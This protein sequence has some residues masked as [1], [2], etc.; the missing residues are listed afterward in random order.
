[1]VKDVNEKQSVDGL[2]QNAVQ[3]DASEILQLYRSMRNGPA[4]W[5]DSYPSM[6]TI[7]FDLSRD[8]LFAMKNDDGEI[9]AVISIDQDEE[10]EALECWSA[11]LSPGGEISRV[12]VKKEYQG[13]G[14]AAKMVQ[15]AMQVLRD[16]KR[17]SIHLLVLEEH[18][19]A[20]GLYQRLGFLR[21]GECDLYGKHFLC[22]EREL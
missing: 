2:I 13:R 22:M 6:E 16:R 1:M 14:I 21:V 12:C 4:K 3:A 17:K 19:T 5:N 18:K 9:I 20:V 15:H 8:S 10:V 11:S 7:A